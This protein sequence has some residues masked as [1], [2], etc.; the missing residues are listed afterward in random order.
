LRLRGG[1]CVAASKTLT[2]KAQRLESSKIHKAKA[3]PEIVML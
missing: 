3:T 1:A 2:A